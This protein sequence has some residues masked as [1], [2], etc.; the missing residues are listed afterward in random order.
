MSA[1]NPFETPKELFH[2]FGWKK[3]RKTDLKK[4]RKKERMKERKNKEEGH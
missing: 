2:T 3:E 1:F 4:E